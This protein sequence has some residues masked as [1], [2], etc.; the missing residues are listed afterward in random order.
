MKKNRRYIACFLLV[1]FITEITMPS[2]TYALTDGPSLPEAS[3]FASVDNSNLVDLFTGDF[4]YTLPLMDVGGYPITLS[5]K[6][7]PTMEQ[8]A[9]WVGLG[10][11]LTPGSINRN[12]RGIPDDF[13][14]ENVN[15]KFK[16]KAN[17][18]YG[19][20]LH[21]SFELFGQSKK[22]KNGKST[23]GKLGMGIFFNSY[24]GMGLTMGLQF[25]HACGGAGKPE[26]ASRIGINLNLNSQEGTDIN[27]SVERRKSE[28]NVEGSPFGTTATSTIGGGIS[29]RTGLKSFNFSKSITDY[30]KGVVDNE[31]KKMSEVVDYTNETGNSISGSISFSKPIFTPAISVPMKSYNYSLSFHYG[32]AI[33]GAFPSAGFDA[34]YSSSEPER[35]N[36]DTRAYGYLNEHN[37]PNEIVLL[38]MSREKDAPLGREPQLLAIPT[39]SYD[40]FSISGEGMN[41]QFRA[42]RSDVGILHDK[43]VRTGSGSASAG[44]E[45]GSGAITHVGGN[46]KGVLNRSTSEQWK[47][48]NKLKFKAQF[49]KTNGAIDYEPAYFKMVTEQVASNQE[50]RDNLQFGDN[51]MMPKLSGHFPLVRAMDEFEILNVP[52][53]QYSTTGKINQSFYRSYRDR[54]STHIAYFTNAEKMRMGIAHWVW[55]MPK[56]S[57]VCFNDGFNNQPACFPAEPPTVRPANQIGEFVITKPDGQVYTYG[58][59]VYNNIQKDVSFAIDEK[60]YPSDGRITYSATDNSL[61]NSQGI[62]N[63]YSA[64]TTPQY[65]HSFLLT[66][67]TSPDYV[68]R[69]NDGPSNDDPGKWVKFNYSRG[70]SAYK[71]RIPY[72]EMSANYNEG[73]HTDELDNKASYI[74]GEKELWNVHSIES[75]NF[76]AIFIVEDRN[77]GLPVINESGGIDP[78]LSKGQVRLK[79]IALYSKAEFLKNG[80]NATPIKTVHFVYENNSNQFGYNLCKN[81][82]NSINKQ[83]GNAGGMNGKL[84]LNGIYFTYGKNTRGAL[85]QYKFTYSD[86]N[87]DYHP[88]AVDRWGNYKRLNSSYNKGNL[89]NH[90]FPYASNNKVQADE[91]ASAWSLTKID[92]PT[93]GSIEVNYESDDYAYVQNKRACEMTYI[94]KIGNSTDYGNANNVLYN[95]NLTSS[96]YWF[97]DAPVPV[98]SKT[99]IKTRYLADL[100]HLYFKVNVD[101]MDGKKEFIEGYADIVDFGIV[102]NNPNVFWV[103]VAGVGGVNPVTK[104]A[105]QLLRNDLQRLAFPHSYNPNNDIV[106]ALKGL[107]SSIGEVGSFFRGYEKRSLKNNRAKN[108]DTEKFWVK[109]SNPYF[110]RLGGG[111][112]VKSIVTSDNWMG[113]TGNEESSFS[114]ITKYTYTDEVKI[115][116][117]V[118]EISSGV[119]SYEPMLGGEENVFRKPLRSTFKSNPLTPS[120]NRFV[121]EPVCEG[122]FPGASVGYSKVKVESVNPTDNE[123]PLNSGFSIHEFYTAKDYPTIAQR[124]KVDPRPSP[125]LRFISSMLGLPIVETLAASQG[126]YVELNDMHGKPKNEVVYS[127]LGVEISGKRYKYI[128]EMTSLGVRH[129]TSKVKGVSKDQQVHDI[130]LGE[131]IDVVMDM[132]D[133]LSLTIG[134]GGSGNIDVIPGPTVPIPIITGAPNLF[135]EYVGVRT[136]VAVKV[137]NRSGILKSVESFREGAISVQENL[138]YDMESGISIVNSSKDEYNRVKYSVSQPAY[139]KYANMGNAYHSAGITFTINPSS[140]ANPITGI[141]NL[142]RKTQL[143]PYL[144]H[145]DILLPST[146]NDELILSKYNVINNF[147]NASNRYWISEP[148]CVSPGSTVGSKVIMDDQGNLL[149]KDFSGNNKGLNDNVSFKVVTSGNKNLLAST[150]ANYNL[151][152]VTGSGVLP[153]QTNQPL[154]LNGHKMIDMS[155]T[156]YNENW[157]LAS[158]N[159]LQRNC[160]TEYA[161]NWPCFSKFLDGLIQILGQTFNAS[162][163]NVLYH[164][165]NEAL[166]IDYLL[167]QAAFDYG[168]SLSQT[169]SLGDFPYDKIYFSPVAPGQ[170]MHTT[171]YAKLGPECYIGIY[172]KDHVEFHLNELIGYTH[173]TQSTLDPTLYGLANS[174]GGTIEFYAFLVCT[175]CENECQEYV[176]NEN[177]NALREGLVNRWLPIRS[178]A[179]N[180]E[181]E[182]DQD[183]ISS[184]SGT[185]SYIP[186]DLPFNSNAGFIS[187]LSANSKWTN[188]NKITK[189]NKQGKEI[190]TIDALQIPSTS[191]DGYNGEVTV[192]VFKN[193]KYH[194]TYFTSFEDLQYWTGRAN[195]ACRSIKWSIEA[196]PEDPNFPYLISSNESHTGKRSIYLDGP[197]SKIVFKSILPLED[198]VDDCNLKVIENKY[199]FDYMNVLP[200]LFLSPGKRYIASVWVKKEVDCETTSFGNNDYN[201]GNITFSNGIGVP[202]PQ[203]FYPKSPEVI[204]EGWQ[205][206]EAIIDAPAI[207]TYTVFKIL[208]ESPTP[209][210]IDDFR[211]VPLKAASSCY[212]YD[213]LTLKLMANLDDNHYA[214]FYEYDD[215]GNLI[216]VKKETERGI[217][218]IKEHRKNVKT[219]IT[220]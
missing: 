19:I 20:T 64:Q 141:I 14:G 134:L 114:K 72:K 195:E 190:E 176:A 80:I 145:G 161:N 26:F 41:G 184:N 117:V 32:A 217:M 116:N 92:L 140:D 85:N 66:S 166:S 105:L 210:F 206:Y 208:F 179:F 12:L 200:K 61:I 135:L 121:E 1:T 199:R 5:Y 96:N 152:S 169:T 98:N 150:I 68:D 123:T 84:T 4:G 108:Y 30:G 212:V 42:F 159:Y 154:N 22:R 142:H 144:K 93:G 171:Y 46:I 127:K 174:T 59:P 175:K 29:T 70:N 202:I 192:G 88:M 146:A 43:K 16:A 9:S 50:Y 147:Q 119:A 110:K 118:Y 196:D 63:F 76:I 36:I 177:F 28:A 17:T 205:L 173:I 18:S 163:V 45:I 155:A 125:N 35:V 11:S 77:D 201:V 97:F 112:R 73:Y 38:D 33:C 87:P 91:D 75:R 213:P 67:I 151:V 56:N 37:K 115:N 128:D 23:N 89:N 94:K 178:W 209:M 168:C 189:V 103:Q 143:T 197:N 102:P 52:S 49:K 188:T 21:P 79:E 83:I 3:G 218:T 156:E 216:R 65:A 164:P 90:F 101:L 6:T 40:L 183:L 160:T 122:Y 132:R 182:V 162:G 74:Y 55:N 58:I 95:S 34:W 104:V 69:L 153:T 129:I 44:V 48:L 71:W 39:H 51:V 219:V 31:K 211:L 137:I 15:K 187:N 99:D 120:D 2:I 215:E 139:W 138:A 82:D 133:H 113:L 194:E 8:E 10:W 149:Y 158:N 193:A 207:G 111:S 136:A 13:N 62:D 27:P 148:I 165:L 180:Q 124:T 220:P 214:T 7:G 25:S 203:Y 106:Q 24:K 131:D 86:V 60:P 126:Y 186:F 157:K 170:A 198:I 204:I 167:N 191:M 109:L 57:F 107:V 78:T 130:T 181:R 185:Y 54:R 100:A 47:N 81:V 172:K 53:N